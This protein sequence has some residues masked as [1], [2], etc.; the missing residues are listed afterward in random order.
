M[1][2]LLG[3]IILAEGIVWLITVVLLGD[4][5][6]AVIRRARVRRRLDRLTGAATEHR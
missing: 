2:L 1:S 6:S 4:R 5:L 3:A